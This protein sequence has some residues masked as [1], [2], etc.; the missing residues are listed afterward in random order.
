MRASRSSSGSGSPS[1]YAS[2]HSTGQDR[3]R[4][5]RQTLLPCSVLTAAHVLQF[6]KEVPDQ[7]TVLRAMFAIGD[8][9]G[10]F[11]QEGRGSSSSANRRT[12]TIS[13]L[14]DRRCLKRIQ[15]PG[16]LRRVRRPPPLRDDV[17]VPRH[18][19]AVQ[20]DGGS[21]STASTNPSTAA[22]STCWSAGMLRGRSLLT[23]NQPRHRTVTLCAS[24]SG[25]RDA[26]STCDPQRTG[27]GALLGHRR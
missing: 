11:N 5:P 12:V 17:P 13:A 9:L 24:R 14:H 3:Q 4:H 18:H 21:A 7:F 2:C 26:G 1:Q 25:G 15:Q 8:D 19:H 22:G 10:S 6:P 20:L 16:P 23:D 27:P